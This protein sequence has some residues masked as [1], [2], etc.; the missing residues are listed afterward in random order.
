MKSTISEF[1]R[2]IEETIQWFISLE[3]SF[4]F[5]LALPFLVGF[6]GFLGEYLRQRRANETN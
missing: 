4:A 1:E 5:L 2:T 6:A 3:P